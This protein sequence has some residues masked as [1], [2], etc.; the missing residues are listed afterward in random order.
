MTIIEIIK[1]LEKTT[2]IT[3]YTDFLK[4]YLKILN[5]AGYDL[6][7]TGEEIK[8][9]ELKE[10]KELFRLR[11]K[12]KKYKFYS[13]F[14]Y[15]YFIDKLDKRIE[16]FKFNNQDIF[17][18]IE[19][20]KFELDKNFNTYLYSVFHKDLL[21]II[22][23]DRGKIIELIENNKLEFGYIYKSRL[24]QSYFISEKYIPTSGLFYQIIFYGYLHSIEHILDTIGIVYM[25][26]INAKL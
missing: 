22:S 13:S 8:E 24:K 1:R 6:E 19:L 20:D 18:K 16:E 2:E 12:Y 17:K 4:D 26:K 21:K 9:K 15:N 11:K 23:D 25:Q 7:N 5:Y 10:L 3:S 14:L